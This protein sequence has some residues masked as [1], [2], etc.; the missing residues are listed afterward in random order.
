ME[1]YP[2]LMERT[3]C[4]TGVKSTPNNVMDYEYTWANRF[5]PEQLKRVRY[6]LTHSPV[7]PGPKLINMTQRRS[8][9]GV[10][11]PPIMVTCPM[12]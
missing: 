12:R 8:T 11:E 6:A 7:L 4:P 3:D 10:P 9:G 2:Y 5:T 1:D